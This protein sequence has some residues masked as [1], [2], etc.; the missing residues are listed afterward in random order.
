MEDSRIDFSNSVQDLQSE[1]TSI[2]RVIGVGGAG[3]S[4]VK[5]MIEIGIEGVNYIVA[6]TDKQ[7]LD[8]NPAPIKVQLGPSITKGLGCGCVPQKGK[9]C[10]IES[11]EEIKAVLQG[12]EMLFVTAGM[13]GGTGTGAAPIIAKTAKDMGILTIGIVSIPYKR[14]QPKKI[15][16]AIEGVKE[17]EASSD[18]VLVVNNERLHDIYGDLPHRKALKCADGVLATATKSLAEIITVYGDSNVDFADVSSALKDSGVALIGTGTARGEDRAVEAVKN[19]ITSPLLNNN[20]I[21]GSHW[22]LVNIFSSEE[23]EMLESEFDKIMGY[24][25]NIAGGNEENFAVKYGTG[26]DESLG[27]ELRVTIVAAGFSDSIFNENTQKEDML[28]VDINEPEN[29]EDEAASRK[30]I[31][32]TD[33][34]ETAN[35]E[36]KIIAQLYDNVR[37]SVVQEETYDTRMLAAPQI[38]PYEQLLNKG[39]LQTIE[40]VPAYQRRAAK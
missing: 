12:A 2:I 30:V 27:D 33:A 31:D 37:S 5:N 15:K 25:S 29:D 32:L 23:H 24:V 16:A 28:V 10:A 8:Q 4:A 36:K 14:E 3:G 13:G 17:M 11:I 21:R 34:D 20:D 18:A 39:I 26:I 9:E 38:L 19:A 1:L 7:A 22:V 35:A 40:N 6:N